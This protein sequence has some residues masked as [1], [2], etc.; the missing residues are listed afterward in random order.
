MRLLDN[1]AVV[2][3]LA[4]ATGRPHMLIEC[5]PGCIGNLRAMQPAVLSSDIVDALDADGRAIVSGD[6]F[7]EGALAFYNA[8]QRLIAERVVGVSLRLAQGNGSVR[9]HEAIV[10]PTVAMPAIAA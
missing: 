5:V 6:D 10:H 2:S 8:E 4:V 1:A 3:A 9:V 7:V